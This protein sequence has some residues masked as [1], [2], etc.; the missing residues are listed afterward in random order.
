MSAYLLPALHFMVSVVASCH[1]LLHKRD[2]RAAIGWIGLIWLSPFLG[3]L[4]YVLLGVNR[5]TR[6]AR[7]IRRGRAR[8]APPLVE[9]CSQELI[10]RTLSPAGAHL[11]PMVELAERVTRRPLLAGNEVEPLV[12]GDEAYP[13][14]LQAID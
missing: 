13:L 4:A 10:E 6:R 7:L 3:T 14:M 1:V 8:P 5:I 11:T 9:P 12:N 2:T